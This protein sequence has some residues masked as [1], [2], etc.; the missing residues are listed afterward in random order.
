MK[1][2]LQCTC[3]AERQ[4]V[5]IDV[6]RL[7]RPG[8]PGRQPRPFPKQAETTRTHTIETT[9]YVQSLFLYVVSMHDA[10]FGAVVTGKVDEEAVDK[11]GGK[12]KK[13][14]KQYLVNV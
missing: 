1:G 2:R 14:A 6:G 4:N 8:V 7:A 12:N 13:Q 3:Q 9:L 10:A 5:R 11:E